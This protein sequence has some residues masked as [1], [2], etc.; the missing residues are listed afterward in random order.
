[1]YRQS[2]ETYGLSLEQGTPAVPRDSYYYVLYL[3]EVIGRF[4]TLNKAQE[5]FAERRKAL[6]ITPT[7]APPVSPEEV[8][9]REMDTMSN[10]RLLWTDED[11][12]RV[13]KKTQGKKGTRSGG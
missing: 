12:I 1:V 10:K 8:R 11:F 7:Q 6:N 4:R 13:S 9:Q 5:L 2:L 3:G